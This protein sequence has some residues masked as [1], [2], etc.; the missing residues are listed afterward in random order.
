MMIRIYSKS[1]K[2][3]LTKKQL[4]DQQDFMASINKIPLPSGGKYPAVATKK[5]K[6]KSLMPY[7]VPR[8]VVSAP[9]LPDT[10][11]GALTK[12]GIMKDYHKLSPADREIVNDVASCTA[13]MHKGNYVYVTPGMNP[14]GLGRKNE[15]L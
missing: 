13:P 12:T 3:K 5:V 15:V 6:E 9:S 4:Q 7:R 14:A 11:K 1:K 8:D 2:K 10:H